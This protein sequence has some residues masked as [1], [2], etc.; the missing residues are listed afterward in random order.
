MLGKLKMDPVGVDY[1]RFTA[2]P[3]IESDRSDTKSPSNDAVEET[4]NMIVNVDCEWKEGIYWCWETTVAT[5]NPEQLR[6][7]LPGMAAKRGSE[8]SGNKSKSRNYD[9]ADDVV[10]V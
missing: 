3:L 6:L 8:H 4:H 1:R 7:D 9:E 2:K 10:G 5:A